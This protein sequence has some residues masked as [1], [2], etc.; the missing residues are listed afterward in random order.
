[1]CDTRNDT[2]IHTYS[3][4]HGCASTVCTSRTRTT[5]CTLCARRTRVR[6]LGKTDSL[7][8]LILGLQSATL[9][10]TKNS[11]VLVMHPNSACS[12]APHSGTTLATSL[13]QPA[14]H[15]H[16]LT[17]SC[18]CYQMT[19]HPMTWL[20]RGTPPRTRPTTPAIAQWLPARDARQSAP[21]L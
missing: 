14:P 11:C 5:C 1:M 16:A 18:Y 21:H 3:T 2:H 19:T 8:V 7:F 10:D 13:T 9:D 20:S 12:S 17:P 15:T 4:S 6:R